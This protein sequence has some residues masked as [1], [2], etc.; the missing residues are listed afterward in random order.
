MFCVFELHS[1]HLW[2]FFLPSVLAPWFSACLSD[3]NEIL[4]LDRRVMFVRRFLGEVHYNVATTHV[5]D[6]SAN[7]SAESV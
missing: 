2:P 5:F 1:P 7:S 6:G 4:M 3:P